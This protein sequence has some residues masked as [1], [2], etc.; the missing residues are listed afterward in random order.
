[1]NYYRALEAASLFKER[2]AECIF[3][4]TELIDENKKRLKQFGVEIPS[5]QERLESILIQLG[6]PKEKVLLGHR[7][8]GG[9]T[10]GE[11]RRIKSMMLENKFNKGIVVTNW[12]HTRR[13]KKI[14]KKIFEDT[15]I[16][17]YVVV[18]KSDKSNPSNW[19]KYRYESIR[20][21]EEFPKL[22]ISYVLPSSNLLFNDDPAD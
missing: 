12:W 7:E 20:V 1:L 21:T 14:Y 3:V 22:L 6:I 2:Y 5:E 18:A 4:S 19:W 11:A 15:N 17:I 9:G 16:R 13:T 8:P 10:V